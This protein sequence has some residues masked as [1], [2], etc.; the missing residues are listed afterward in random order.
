[1]KTCA[2][3]EGEKPVAQLNPVATEESYTIF[4][5]L[6]GKAKITGD[7]VSPLY[8]DEELESFFE[9]SASLLK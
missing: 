1:M 9:H 8:S 5:F 7:I 4:G 3:Y 2:Y 6:R